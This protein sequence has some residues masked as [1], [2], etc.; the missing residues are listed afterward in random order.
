MDWAL[1][2]MLSDEDRRRVQAAAHRRRFERRE[3]LF[4]EGDPGDTLH[5]IRKGRVAVRVT[6]RLGDVTTL[7]I[8]GP[9][10]VVGELALVTQPGRRTATA[11][12]LEPVETYALYRP[13]FLEL[14]R[15]HPSVDRLLVE[16]LAAVVVRLDQLVVEA[17]Y[18]PA[19]KRVVRRL[20]AATGVYGGAAS[21]TEVP[22]TQEQLASLAG[23]SRATVNRV[24]RD[25]EDAGELELARGRIR[26]LAP[27]AL[28]RRGR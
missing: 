2:R 22:L 6:T 25:A 4:H 3:V 15:Q 1:L 28:A 8:L 11:I 24:L 23:T 9:G 19:D 18:V 13:D 17:L 5:L 14:R 21:G 7:A 16:L 10:D 20:L 12:A 27:E 26:I